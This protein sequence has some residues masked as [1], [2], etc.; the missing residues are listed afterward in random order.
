MKEIYIEDLK[1]KDIIQ[2]FK[3]HSLR[4]ELY[5]ILEIYKSE[6]NKRIFECQEMK[7]TEE[8]DLV[9]TIEVCF[10]NE[11]DV[12]GIYNKVKRK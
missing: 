12:Y 1:T 4:L 7:F 9:P 10:I 5:K 6:D 2:V 11:N 8:K 3:L